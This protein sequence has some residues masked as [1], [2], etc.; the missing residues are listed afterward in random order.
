MIVK[1]LKTK[2]VVTDLVKAVPE[3]HKKFLADMV[4]VHEEVRINQFCF[5]CFCRITRINHWVFLFFV[6]SFLLYTILV[7]K[8]KTKR[9]FFGQDDVC[10]TT[11]DGTKHCRLIAVHAGLE[12]GKDVGEQLRLLKAKDTRVAKIEAIAGRKNVWDIP[13]VMNFITYDKAF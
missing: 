13:E 11:P 12:K 10:I 3:E 5:L 4:L 1:I 8:T 2:F 9:S 6:T 7:S